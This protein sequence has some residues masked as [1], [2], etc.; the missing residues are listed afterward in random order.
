MGLILGIDIC[1]DCSQI[2]SYNPD[3]GDVESITLG[4]EAAA[5]RIPT[6][7]CKKNGLDEWLIGEEAF[8]A[9]LTG[10]GTLVDRLIKLTGKNGSA[11][12]EGTKYTAEQLIYKYIEKLIDLAAR[13][14]GVEEL[15]SIVFTLHDPGPRINDMLIRCAEKRGISRQ[16]VHIYSHTETFAYYI[17]S[18]SSDI[19]MNQVSLFDLRENGLFYY[20]MRAI[21]G[22]KPIVVEAR[23]EKIPEVFALSVLD[24]PAGEK[25]ADKILSSCASR[26]LDKKS[27]SSVVLTGKGFI[28]TAWAHDFLEVICNRRR[29]FYA[30]QIFAQGAAYAAADH[31]AEK[32]KFNYLMICDGRLASNVSVNA[33]ADGRKE[34]IMLANAGSNWYEAGSK[35]MFILDDIH[36]LDIDVYSAITDK[37]RKIEISLGELPARPAK[38]TRIEVVLSFS[39]EKK[40]TVRV[41][42]RGFGDLFPSSEKVIRED[43]TI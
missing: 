19:W 29:V 39:S 9:A 11:T 27:I 15:D 41:Y 3:L 4:G 36:K 28:D 6:V 2:S 33:I 10:G 24:T 7:I 38:T 13:R 12:I 32:S 35:A 34:Q 22:R 42:D 30:G 8:R 17:L 21:R 43:F 23:R 26:V 14:Y 40:M 1:D 31:I 16:L 37:S 5:D 25:I 18:Q 20:E